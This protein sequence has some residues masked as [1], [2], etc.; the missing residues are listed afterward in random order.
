M[1]QQK[2]LSSSYKVA[3]FSL[4]TIGKMQLYFTNKSAVFLNKKPFIDCTAHFI[5]VLHDIRIATRTISFSDTS[6]VPQAISKYLKPVT[7]SVIVS[8][9]STFLP[10]T[11]QHLLFRS[12]RVLRGVFR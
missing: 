9:V 12:I 11:A 5:P 6:E 1:M 7:Y 4:V 2:P 3:L 10:V 8:A